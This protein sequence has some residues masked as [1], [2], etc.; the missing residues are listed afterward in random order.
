MGLPVSARGGLGARWAI[1]NVAATVGVFEDYSD[2]EIIDV[3]G[4]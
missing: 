3:P 1:E 2:D 4:A